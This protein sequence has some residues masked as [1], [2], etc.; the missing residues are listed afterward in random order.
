MTPF[1]LCDLNPPDAQLPLADLYSASTLQRETIL[2]KVNANSSD[3]FLKSRTCR[4]VQRHTVRG[5]GAVL[6]PVP[7]S[8]LLSE[9]LHLCPH[10][11]VAVLPHTVLSKRGA[12]DVQGVLESLCGQ[13]STLLT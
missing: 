5:P 12:R 9:K 13:T 4:N 1:Y 3:T 2:M 8:H 11:L 10:V 6:V 7:P